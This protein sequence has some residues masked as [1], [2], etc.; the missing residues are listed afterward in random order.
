MYQV[1]IYYSTDFH[2]YGTFFTS[3]TEDFNFYGFISR[4]SKVSIMYCSSQKME[5]YCNVMFSVMYCEKMY[6]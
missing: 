2:K 1:K 3:S 5:M 4:V 6:T